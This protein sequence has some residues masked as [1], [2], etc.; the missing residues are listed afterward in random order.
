M[1]RQVEIM[2]SID[3]FWLYMDH[4]TNLMIITGF[5]A[6]DKPLDYDRMVE[7]FKNRLLCY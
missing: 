7:T 2:S 6:F 5:L 1:T 3:N 4:P